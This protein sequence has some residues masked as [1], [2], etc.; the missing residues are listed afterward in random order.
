M[1]N[2]GN[3]MP[4]E[5]IGAAHSPGHEV[6][7]GSLGQGLSQAAADALFSYS[8]PG[9]LRELDRVLLTAVALTEGDVIE[10][11]SLL[12]QRIGAGERAAGTPA[13]PEL[14]PDG[15]LS[16]R[17]LEVAHVRRVLAMVGGNKA[18]AASLLGISARTIYRK[19]A[20]SDDEIE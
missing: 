7:S 10:E 8:W 16:L 17:A 13:L 15:D 5:M 6:M 2:S 3:R 19:R 18:Q 14:T 11:E 1:P 4:V 9:N 12:V 20:P